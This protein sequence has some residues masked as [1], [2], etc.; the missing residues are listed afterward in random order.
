M[1]WPSRRPAARHVGS[2]VDAFLTGKPR[3]AFRG[4][5]WP[6]SGG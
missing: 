3:F 5:D 2:D 4:T 6:L 1:R